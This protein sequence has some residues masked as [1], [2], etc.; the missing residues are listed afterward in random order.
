MHCHQRI[1]IKF[2][3]NERADGGNSA[4]RRQAQFGE[5]ISQ[6][7]TVQFWIPEVWIG[8]QDL[9]DEIR[10]GRLPP[11]DLNAKILAILSLFHFKWAHSIAETLRIVHSIVLLHL[12]DFNCFPSFHL[13]EVSYELCE[14]RMEHAQARLPNVMADIFW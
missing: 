14:K 13:H 12:Q 9:H 3:L 10:G 4:D 1:I 6:L 8:R 2:L 5:H 11:D 7:R